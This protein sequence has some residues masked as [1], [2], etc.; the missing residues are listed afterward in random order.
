MNEGLLDAASVFGH[1]SPSYHIPMT[2]LFGPE[3]QIYSASDA[4]NRANL[5]Y[6]FMYS[7]WP[8]NPAPL[9]L[10]LTLLVQLATLLGPL[11]LLSL[12]F[13]VAPLIFSLAPLLVLRLSVGVPALF[14][15]LPSLL[16]CTLTS[17]YRVIADARFLGPSMNRGC[18]AIL[19]LPKPNPTGRCDR[20]SS[21][22]LLLRLYASS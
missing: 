17:A 6:S 13:A 14:L 19:V 20:A 2:A 22:Q 9:F 4:I 18:G 15:R 7:P 10:S 12:P 3:F 16:L 5:F 1:Y 8:I 11:L 21:I